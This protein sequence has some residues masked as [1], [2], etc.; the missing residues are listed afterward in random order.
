MDNHII[1][2]RCCYHFWLKR[3][4]LMQRQH[5]ER[6]SPKDI[7]CKISQYK[8]ITTHNIPDRSSIVENG[9]VK[10]FDLAQLYQ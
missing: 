5:G 4:H 8:I 10:V 1:Q 3:T 2:I 7:G 9:I 6:L